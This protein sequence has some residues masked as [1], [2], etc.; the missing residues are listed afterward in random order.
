MSIRTKE[1]V[2]PDFLWYHRLVRAR[3]HAGLQQIDL[4]RYMGLSRGA[5]SLYERGVHKPKL[6]VL[7]H[8]ADLCGVDLDWLLEG[9][10]P[11]GPATVN[12]PARTMRSAVGSRRSKQDALPTGKWRVLA[13]A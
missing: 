5:I 4:A 1:G 9:I 13:A 6:L 8:W 11:T 7:R 10:E 3:E 12:A 2:R